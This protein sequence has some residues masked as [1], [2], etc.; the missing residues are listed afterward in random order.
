[1]NLIKIRLLSGG[2]RGYRQIIRFSKIS[3]VNGNLIIDCPTCNDALI[4]VQQFN[5]DLYLVSKQLKVVETIE[6]KGDGKT[7]HK[8]HKV[9]LLGV[10]F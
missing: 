9:D 3:F 5:T 6:I 7:I 2:R 10:G 4:L 8:L 1:M